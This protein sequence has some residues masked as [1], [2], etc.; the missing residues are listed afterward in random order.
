MHAK[1]VKKSNYSKELEDKLKWLYKNILKI[2]EYNPK[3]EWKFGEV[4]SDYLDAD[5]LS[6]EKQK[7]I[8]D[9][10]DKLI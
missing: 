8:L 9:L 2:R 3:A 4:Y 7:F 1:Y 5:K 6:P 10:Y